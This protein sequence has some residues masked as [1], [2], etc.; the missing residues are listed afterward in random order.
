[1]IV[2]CI[3]LPP[4]TFATN[5]KEVLRETSNIR[6]SSTATNVSYMLHRLLYL[7]SNGFENDKK[8]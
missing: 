3:Y 5:S 7:M 2:C 4:P 6:W 8:Y 1:M